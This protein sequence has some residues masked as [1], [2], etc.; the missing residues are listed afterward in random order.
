V[1][2]KLYYGDNLQV[3]RDDIGDESVDL[4]YLDP[5][6]NS[7]ATYNVLFR[8][9]TGEAAESQ[10]EAFEDSWHWNDHAEDAFDQVIRSGNSDAAELLRAMRAFLG[11]NDMMAYLAMMAVRLLELH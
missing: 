4:I 5:P 3:L 7:N 8:S 2:N 1:A 10:I 11:D 9:P 6:F